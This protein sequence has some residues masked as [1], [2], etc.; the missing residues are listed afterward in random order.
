[1]RLTA[2][3]VLPSTRNWPPS[4]GARVAPA[5][6]E[7]P[8]NSVK[9]SVAVLLHADIRE[10]QPPSHTEVTLSLIAAVVTTNDLDRYSGNW[11]SE[12]IERNRKRANLH[13]VRH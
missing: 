9:E 11:H 4:A 8:G 6:F 3:G 2:P 7:V 10:A 12:V 5:V 13:V 1:M